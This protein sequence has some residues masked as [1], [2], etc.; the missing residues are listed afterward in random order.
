MSETLTASGEVSTPLLYVESKIL[1]RTRVYWV[2]LPAGEGSLAVDAMIRG[3]SV[4]AL[5]IRCTV[6]TLFI[7]LGTVL[8]SDEALFLLATQEQTE[9]ESGT[10]N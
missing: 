4:A 8:S 6:F 10:R 7:S 5:N 9:G 1:T 2:N 3:C